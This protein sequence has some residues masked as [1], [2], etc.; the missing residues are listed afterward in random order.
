VLEGLTLDLG[1]PIVEVR[2][3]V[4]RDGDAGTFEGEATVRRMAF[5]RLSRYWPPDVAA[6]G[7]RWIFANLADGTIPEARAKIAGRFTAGQKVSAEVSQL[8]ATAELRGFTVHYLRPLYPVRKVDATAV[9]TQDRMDVGF[10]AGNLEGM[11]LRE[12]TLAMTALD[13]DIPRAAIEVVLGG[14]IEHALRV[15]DHPKLRYA[16]RIGFDAATAR[17]QAAIRLVTRLPLTKSVTMD[18]VELKAA[19]NLN[20][21]SAPRAVLGRDLGEGRFTVQLDRQGMSIEGKAKL[22]GVDGDV[23]WYENFLDEAPYSR[24]YD[25]KAV[26]DDAARRRFGLDLPN[27]FTGP[28]AVNLVVIETASSGQTMVANLD[29]TPATLT[30]PRLGWSKDAGQ[31]GKAT[32]EITLKDGRITEIPAFQ[33]SAAGL[34]AQGNVQFGANGETIRSVRLSRFSLGRRTNFHATAQR[35]DDGTY[36]V[37]LSGP[38]LDLA[39]LLDAQED[40]ENETNPPPV[41]LHAKVDRLWIGPDTAL[42]TIESV[43]HF[44]GETW[45]RISVDGAIGE[46]RRLVAHYHNEAGH[47]RIEVKS[48]DAGGLLNGS[49]LFEN[50]RGGS[51]SL[52]GERTGGT[53]ETPWKGRLKIDDFKIVRAP[54]VARL[55]TL[56]SF[57]GISN[58]VSGEGIRFETLD[59]PFT[60]KSRRLSIFDARAV[61]SEIGITARGD[62]DLGAERVAL[63][64]TLVPAYTINSILGAIP[65]LG[66]LLTGDKGGGVFAATYKIEGPFE[67]TKISVNPLAALTP[68]FLRDLVRGIGRSSSPAPIDPPLND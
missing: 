16:S 15:V 28:V 51:L 50:M 65:F 62:I 49:G 56:A 34:V 5:D 8:K 57:T 20:G 40:G 25:V 18:E 2:A 61:G 23:K 37:T 26:L 46:N 11:T 41:K 39:P 3:V 68:G 29:L 36:V 55:L 1:G 35:I 60:M 42:A 22:D 53:D 12:G 59:M 66:K 4:T 13:K 21:V 43:V 6:G 24:R 64:G 27:V 32:L 14:S 67:S 52:T 10:R 44:D 19:A 47:R 30:L 63:E 38:S 54:I 31:S 9:I 45:R 33:A 58:L 7:R 17:G 48:A